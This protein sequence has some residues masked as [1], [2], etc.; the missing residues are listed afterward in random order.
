LDKES[1]TLKAT[2][3]F[4][5]DQELIKVHKLDQLCEFRRGAAPPSDE[6]RR[7]ARERLSRAID[8]EARLETALDSEPTQRTSVRR[9]IVNNRATPLALGIVA[10]A[11]AVALFLSAPWND[12]PGFLAKA[13]AALTPPPGSVLHMKWETTST[14]TTRGCTV[15]RTNEI[16]I[17]QTPQHRYR[18]YLQDYPPAAD[19][20][21]GTTSEVGGTFDPLD[22]FRFKPPNTLI[23]EALSFNFG[24]PTEPVR[25]ALDR[26]FAHDEG[27][28]QL[29]GRTVRRIRIDAPPSGEPTYVYVDPATH[30]PVEIRT[31]GYAAPGTT[32]VKEADIVMRFLVFEHLPPTGANLALTNIRAQHPNAT[33]LPP[34]ARTYSN[35][36][37]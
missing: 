15:T 19:C 37:G 11:G 30:Y 33:E 18:G 21:Q 8:A 5:Q 22:T 25:G 28:T 31:A 6:A 7:R 32:L 4:S 17:D 23:R 1:S 13:Q 2:F 34:A 36:P 35:M 9:W 24:D 29:D 14:P 16:W 12:S 27:E 26:G 10:A 3:L 20:S